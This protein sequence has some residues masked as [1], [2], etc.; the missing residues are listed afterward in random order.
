MSNASF[1]ALVVNKDEEGF[2][3]AV[4]PLAL[5]DLPQG[6]VLVQVAYSGVNY[7]DGLAGTPNG[8]IVRQ[9]PFVP[10][11]DLAGTVLESNDSR[12]YKGQKVLATGFGLGVTHYGGFSEIARVPADWLTPLP[13][14]LSLK[15][16]MIV[17]TAGLTA[18]ISIE[19][20]E[21]Q[22]AAPE[23]GEVLVTGATGG[24]G[25]HA[26]AMLAAKGY[27]VIASTGR[28]ESAADYLKQVGASQVI[29][30]ISEVYDNSK[31]LQSTSWQAAIDSVGGPPLAIILS[32][33][34]YGGSVALSGLTGGVEIPT[35]VMPFILRGVKLVGIDSV[36]YPAEKRLPLWER[37]G[38][39]LRP[40]C[41]DMFVDRQIELE[42]LPEA[43]ED[44]L[45]A[46][47]VGR[48]LVS[49]RPDKNRN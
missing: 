18:A 10:G 14:S 43:F 28:H 36:S 30:R 45:H 46:R 22:G 5:Y 24:V 16:A 33:I 37:I 44:I 3:T 25:S 17:G 20:L 21:E 31:P 7:K 48:I 15:E 1:N 38:G 34:S 40:A 39:D 9:Y 2:S 49:I 6:E 12:F 13:A 42:Q 4:K 47:T 8:K 35:T 19:Q 29:P 23:K 11:I 27:S 26:I 41:F 32:K